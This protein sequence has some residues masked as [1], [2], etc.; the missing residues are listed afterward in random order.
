MD[1]DEIDRIEATLL[2]AI[3]EAKVVVKERGVGPQFREIVRHAR[4]M[5]D[6]LLGVLRDGGSQATQR[7]WGLCIALGNAVDELE[8]LDFLADG[9]YW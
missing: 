6:L 2:Q 7:M 4:E 3:G 1:A 5:H 9:R 8:L